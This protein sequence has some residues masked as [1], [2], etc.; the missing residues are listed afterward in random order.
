MP[1]ASVIHKGLR[2]FMS[3]HKVRIG[4]EKLELMTE[5]RQ[6]ELRDE[7]LRRSMVGM[8]RMHY[9]SRD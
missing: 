2:W 8:M 3:R 7:I 5:Y 4:G 9:T 6:S 1:E